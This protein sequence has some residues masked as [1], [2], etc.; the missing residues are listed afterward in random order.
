MIL[1]Y[2]D[3]YLTYLDD[4]SQWKVTK[5]LTVGM[6]NMANSPRSTASRLGAT[7]AAGAAAA[8]ADAQ[9]TGGKTRASARRV[10]VFLRRSHGPMVLVVGDMVSL[11]AAPCLILV[12]SY[13]IV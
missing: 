1:I 13:R 7:S 5:V 11:L 3:I 2:F 4:L 6:A 12:H 10:M 9:P 8:W